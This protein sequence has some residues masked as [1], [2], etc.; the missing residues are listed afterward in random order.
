MPLSSKQTTLHRETL[1]QGSGGLKINVLGECCYHNAPHPASSLGLLG[2]LASFNSQG[3]FQWPSAA[4]LAC[5]LAPVGFLSAELLAQLCCS[6]APMHRTFIASQAQNYIHSSETVAG[7][8]LSLA[9][10]GSYYLCV[11]GAVQ[12]RFDRPQC[13]LENSVHIC[14]CCWK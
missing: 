9:W 2:S 12:S 11:I 1:S 14:H 4:L 3:S 10:P 6:S 7:A 13:P 5:V 8:N